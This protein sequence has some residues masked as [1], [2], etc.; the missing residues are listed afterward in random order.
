MAGYGSIDVGPGG[1]VVIALRKV[2]VKGTYL[3]QLQNNNRYWVNV[4][5]DGLADDSFS[6]KREFAMVAIGD[7][8][9]FPATPHNTYLG[10]GI[11]Q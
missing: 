5:K 9:D 8:S 7:L 1:E 4:L 3:E 11:P 10:T 2:N 6:Q